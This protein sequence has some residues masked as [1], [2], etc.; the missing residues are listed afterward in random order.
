MTVETSDDSRDNS[1][2][3]CSSSNYN[4]TASSEL[5]LFQSMITHKPAG[6]N[7]HF[8]MAVVSEK[9]GSE[10]GSDVTSDAIW[11]KLKTMFDL[12]AVDDRE[13]VIPFPLEEKE[14]CLP[15]R[16]FNT[17]IVDKLKEINK[18]KTAGKSSKSVN[19]V[20]QDM[21]SDTSALK[22]EKDTPKVVVK[23]DSSKNL[24]KSDVK[25]ES[26]EESGS[27]SKA[28]TKRHAT[29]STPSNTPAKKRK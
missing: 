17:L 20:S 1:L 12:T 25:P 19:R 18:D 22:K 26:K 27:G 3:S 13:E 4:W 10:F 29:R 11:N 21:G 5:A 15:R 2:S 6:I 8:S 7:K 28:P 24:V 14:F 23:T 9:L 16:D